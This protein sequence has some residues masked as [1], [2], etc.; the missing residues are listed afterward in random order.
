MI[1]M[2]LAALP[3]DLLSRVLSQVD[4]S[5]R[6]R[7]HQV[8]R[9]WNDVLLSPACNDMW[10][11]TPFIDLHPVRTQWIERRVK[12]SRLAHWLSARAATLG[13]LQISCGSLLRRTDGDN[14][15]GGM[16]DTLYFAEKVLPYLLGLLEFRG[17]RLK[18]RCLFGEAEPPGTLHL[19]PYTSQP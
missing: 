10:H 4:F 2:R 12:F 19:G 14:E 15:E 6:C 18:L 5:S 3:D 8:C 11:D 17:L 1:I 7:A 9:K 16:T 13:V